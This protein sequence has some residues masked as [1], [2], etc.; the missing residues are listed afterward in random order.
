MIWRLTSLWIVSKIS[1]KITWYWYGWIKSKR[2]KYAILDQIIYSKILF[3]KWERKPQADSNSW[4]A[5]HKI[6]TLATELWRYSIKSIGTNRLKTHL[7]RHL[8]TYTCS[9]L[10]SIRCSEIIWAYQ[11][12]KIKS[13]PLNSIKFPLHVFDALVKIQHFDQQK[14]DLSWFYLDHVTSTLCK[15]WIDARMQ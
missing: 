3:G 14:N 7:N 13:P 8:M 12:L 11:F 5:V 15:W 10:K 6:D 9:V 4:S 2:Q 1:K